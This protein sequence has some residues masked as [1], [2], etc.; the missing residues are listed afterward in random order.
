MSQYQ[1]EHYYPVDDWAWSVKIVT[2]PRQDN[3]AECGVFVLMRMYCMMKGWD[4]NSIEVTAYNSKLRLCV[5][6]MTLGCKLG[7]ED[8]KFHHNPPPNRDL[9]LLPYSGFDSM[10]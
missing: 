10:Y 9:F 1:R 2:S 4:F 3:G 5:M 6:Y 7:D 8:Y